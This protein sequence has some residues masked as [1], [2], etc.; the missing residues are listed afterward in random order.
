ME[1]A[2]VKELFVLGRVS[3]RATHGHEI[4][5]TLRVSRSDLW[6]ELSEK[7]VYYVLRKLERD[8]LVSATEERAG[9]LPARKVYAITEAGRTALAA[10]M[11][12]DNLVRATPYSEFDVLLGMLC[13]TG[14]LDAAA[15]SAILERRR[16]VLAAKLE[17]LLAPSTAADAGR[18]A[19]GFPAVM[20][21]KVARGVR[22]EI[23]WLEGVMSR[24][25]RDG[26]DSLRPV[27][28]PA[29]AVR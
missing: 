14:V 6:V 27:F 20:L 8:G 17:G 5:R 3:L 28:D 7:H 19:G 22:S 16:A 10:M 21:D 18:E 1:S 26:W 11:E 12:A 24:V 4:M 15:K 25:E 13:Y 9:A 2:S 29:V 23:E